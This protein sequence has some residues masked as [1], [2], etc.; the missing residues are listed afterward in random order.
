[1]NMLYVAYF[2]FLYASIIFTRLAM[3]TFQSKDYWYHLARYSTMSDA[4]KQYYIQ[5]TR[6]ALYWLNAD[7][8]Y[9]N[10]GDLHNLAEA[11]FA[12]GNVASICRTC[13]LL[14]IIPFVGPLQVKRERE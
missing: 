3:N 13:F 6:H 11:F 7:R 2:I 4:E 9:W 5:Q 14:P 8:F 10:G 12:M 1:M